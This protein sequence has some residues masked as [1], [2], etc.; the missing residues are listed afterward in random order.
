[1]YC[2]VEEA[3]LEI[4]KG[5]MLV[6]VDDEN[7]ENEGDLLMAAKYATPEAINFMATHGKGLICVPMTKVHAQKYGLEAMV[8]HSSDPKETAFTVSVDLKGSHTGISAFERSA[9]ILALA[10]ENA[11]ARDFTSPGHIFP[12]IAKNKGVLE[13]EGHTEAAVDLARLAGLMPMGVICEIMNEDGTMASGDKLV[14]FCQKHGLKCLTI[15]ALKAYLQKEKSQ[16][17]QFSAR[18]MLPTAYGD[19]K[20]MG[21]ACEDGSHHL[22]LVLGDLSQEQVPLVR[23][24]SEC[25]TGDVFGSMKCDCG[26]QLNK[27]LERIKCAGAGALI[28]LKQEG[29]GIGLINKIK[30]YALQEKGMDTAEANVALGFEEDLRDYRVAGEMLK[31]LGVERVRLLTNNPDKVKALTDMGIL[32]VER[33]AIMG[34]ECAHNVRYLNTKKEKM[35]HWL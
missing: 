8:K 25:L 2:T 19:F 18:A 24:H 20:M 12:L 4:K 1:M 28:Y 31:A 14:R 11:S 7:R 23:I 9:T 26:D 30:A 22:A 34:N 29:R 10:K 21:Y 35:G 17:G 33:L 6:V 3:I 5:R 13:R 27:S 32:V 16:C 15:E